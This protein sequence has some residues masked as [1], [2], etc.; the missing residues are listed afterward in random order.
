[1]LSDRLSGKIKTNCLQS[2]CENVFK[3]VASFEI[4]T[5]VVLEGRSNKMN[6]P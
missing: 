6:K 3:F 4:L 5:F 1:M 2:S